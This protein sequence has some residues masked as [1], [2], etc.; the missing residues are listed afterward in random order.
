MTK[1]IR[2]EHMGHAVE[3]DGRGKDL[4][5]QSTIHTWNPENDGKYKYDSVQTYI[6]NKHGYRSPEFKEG[7]KLVFGGCSYTYGVGI[8]EKAIW[9]VQL[10]EKMGVDYANVSMPGASVP[11]VIDQ[12]L[13]YCREFGNPEYIALAFPNFYRGVYIQNQDVLVHEGYES[14]HGLEIDVAFYNLM[15]VDAKK[16]PK[17]SKRPHVVDEVTPPETPVYHAMKSIRFLEQ[18]CEA[19]GIKLW[20]AFIESSSEITSREIQEQYGF[21]N[22]IDLHRDEWSNHYKPDLY[23]WFLKADHSDPEV[24]A[25]CACRR[26]KPCDMFEKCHEDQREIWGEDFDL[27]SDRDLSL[28]SAHMGVHSQI[29]IA[30]DFYRS[31]SAQL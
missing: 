25:N 5:F 26:S 17:V 28:E 6:L 22:R 13:S 9:G 31:I 1:P 14:A 18:Y 12:V 24:N 21:K 19:A 29:H 20:W 15:Q 16:Y 10:A 8:P 30:E 23:G 2:L 11:W 27:A 7:T 3:F 4:I